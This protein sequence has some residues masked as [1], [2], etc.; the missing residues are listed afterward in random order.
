MSKKDYKGVIF[1]RNILTIIVLLCLASGVCAVPV[2]QLEDMNI[3]HYIYEGEGDDFFRIE[4][5]KDSSL[6]FAAGNDQERHFAIT[7]Y[8][9]EGNRTNL[10]VNTTSTYQ[11]VV[12][13]DFMDGQNTVEL[14]IR[15]TGD[16]TVSTLP[17]DFAPRLEVPGVFK[18]SGDNVLV[19]EGEPSRARVEGN[20]AEQH[21]A[22]QGYGNLRHLLV[23]TTSKYSGT[24]RVPSD[25]IVLEITAHN[26]WVIETE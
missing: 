15:A 13:L 10:F 23:N 20:E 2:E 19:L 12:P 21:F 17:L 8:D 11:G 9:A 7:G 16:W 18:G 14:E 4:K 3:E 6:L 1:V 5:P 26:E 24:V 25:V 22:L